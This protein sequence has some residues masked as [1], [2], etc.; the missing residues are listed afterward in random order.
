M[1]AMVAPGEFGSVYTEDN[2]ND[3]RKGKR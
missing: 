2:E 3:L 1:D